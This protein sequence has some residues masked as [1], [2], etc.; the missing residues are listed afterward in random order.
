M[1]KLYTDA[2]TN[3]T[4][5][6]AGILVIAEQKQHQIKQKITASN[7]HQAEFEAAILGLL[8][9]CFDTFRM[10]KMSSFYSDSKIVIDS[11]DKRYSKS[12]APEL[13]KLLAL[14]E[15]FPLVIAQWIPDKQNAGAHNLALQALKA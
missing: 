1:V 5:S 7:N 14:Q 3:K 12:F 13:T 15:K 10:R 11:L 6:A 2:A 8:N 9:I 4:H